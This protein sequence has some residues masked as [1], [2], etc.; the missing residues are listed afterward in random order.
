MGLS[1]GTCLRDLKKKE[2]GHRSH[3]GSLNQ[4]ASKGPR[5]ALASW[6]GPR[7]LAHACSLP[8]AALPESRV[9]IYFLFAFCFSLFV[10]SL[11]VF[12]AGQ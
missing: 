11:F 9:R 7:A 5:R 10:F 6:N 4:D 12:R 1:F 3:F 2:K 8:A